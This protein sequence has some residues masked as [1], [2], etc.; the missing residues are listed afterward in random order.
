F[1]GC[2]EQAERVREG[3]RQVCAEIFVVPQ[4]D[5]V[6]R[7]IPGS[8]QDRDAVPLDR[9][10]AERI[11]GGYGG[12][13]MPEG[14]D[15][16]NEQG[17]HLAVATVGSRAVTVPDYPHSHASRSLLLRRVREHHRQD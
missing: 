9:G 2:P 1:A 14:G 16:G 8:P 3:D 6:P 12:D 10:T 17:G 15:P 4:D 7:D 13:L 5:V 11:R